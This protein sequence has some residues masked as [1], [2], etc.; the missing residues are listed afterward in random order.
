MRL[1]GKK[2][3]RV[4]VGCGRDCRVEIRDP[5]PL[6]DDCLAEP[7]GPRPVGYVRFVDGERKD[8]RDEPD[9]EEV[10]PC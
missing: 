7:D 5:H 6:C 3:V 10:A 2:G 9:I 4:C 8:Y 1:L